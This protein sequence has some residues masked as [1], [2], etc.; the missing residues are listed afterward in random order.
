MATSSAALLI[1]LIALPFG[2]SCLAALFP[3]NARNAEA[4]LAG[5]VALTALA[6]V[7]ALY[8]QVANGGVVQYR[9]PWVPE[10]GLEFNLR[11]DGFAW[12]LAALVTGIG[13]L[14]VLYARY[15]MSPADPVPRFYSFLLAFMAAPKRGEL[16]A[17]PRNPTINGCSESK[18]VA[19]SNS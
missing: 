16:H 1:V 17:K 3:A 6:L 4:Y 5:G 2:G 13:L 9:A 8:S 15:Y 12:L 14:V 19:H 7:I 18:A 10:L 11:M